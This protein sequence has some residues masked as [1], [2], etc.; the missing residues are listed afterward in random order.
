MSES[1]SES[2]DASANRGMRC[3]RTDDNVE[4]RHATGASRQQYA[5]LR[6]IIL[7][8][9]GHVSEALLRLEGFAPWPLAWFLWFVACWPGIAAGIIARWSR[10][11]TSAALLRLHLLN[12]AIVIAMI[13]WS[14]AARS[15]TPLYITIIAEIVLVYAVIA[16]V[17]RE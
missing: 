14:Y 12:A 8:L 15:D 1:S 10:F 5:V 9:F 7:S 11:A 6:F 3:S 2:W 16:R 13:E 4:R 17:R